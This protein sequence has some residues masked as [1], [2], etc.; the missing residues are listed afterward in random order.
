MSAFQPTLPLLEIKTTGQLQ[1]HKQRTDY[2]PAA[3]L[4][5]LSADFFT[6][7]FLRRV[8]CPSRQKSIASASD[9]TEYWGA[10]ISTRRGA[11]QWN[12]F[13]LVPPVNAEVGFV[14]RDQ[15]VARMKFAHSNEA[16]IGKIRIAVRISKC[17]FP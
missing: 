2:C 14:N 10:R 7:N 17:Q 6:S 11:A 15:D 4:V 1:R 9:F 12:C 3:P 8:S 16:K 13:P 5:P